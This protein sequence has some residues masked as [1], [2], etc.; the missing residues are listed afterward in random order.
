MS[1]GL[2]SPAFLCDTALAGLRARDCVRVSVR[3]V[4]TSGHVHRCT[5]HHTRAC[6]VEGG[7]GG[8]LWKSEPTNPGQFVE[9]A[10][11]LPLRQWADHFFKSIFYC[12]TLNI[13][14]VNTHTHIYN[15]YIYVCVYIYI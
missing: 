11:L 4:C 2:I 8:F 5:A 14:F 9:Y 6:Q 13:V 1:F 3:F 15:I 10:M 7:L 12:Q